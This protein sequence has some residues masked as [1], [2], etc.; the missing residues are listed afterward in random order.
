MSNYYE[1]TIVL[2]LPFEIQ[3]LK[4]KAVAISLEM[5]LIMDDDMKE[6]KKM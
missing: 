5:A 3:N 6:G 2:E 1:F 4:M